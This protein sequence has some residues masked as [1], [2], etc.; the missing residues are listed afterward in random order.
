MKRLVRLSIIL[1]FF[2]AMAHAIDSSGNYAVWG[3]G[4]KSCFGYNKSMAEEDGSKNFKSY[5]KGFLTAYNIFTAETYN[6]SGRKDENGVLEWLREYCENNPMSSLENA[7]TNFTFEHHD[8]RMKT[9]RQT[10]SR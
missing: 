10:F 5:I 8:K 7:L 3:V 6:I 4:K 9:S 2:P 1:L